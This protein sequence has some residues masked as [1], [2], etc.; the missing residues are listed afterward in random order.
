MFYSLKDFLFMCVWGGGSQFFGGEGEELFHY[1]QRE[2]HDFLAILFFFFL[3]LGAI[4]RVPLLNNG[5]S[6]KMFLKY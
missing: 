4:S 5:W 2:G 6:L 3:H 1:K